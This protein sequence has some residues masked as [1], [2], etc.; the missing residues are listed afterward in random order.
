MTS[1][2]DEMDGSEML[3]L[4]TPA[5]LA[6]M[7]L[8]SAVNG[9]VQVQQMK[10]LQSGISQSSQV[11]EAAQMQTAVAKGIPHAPMQMKLTDANTELPTTLNKALN[12]LSLKSSVENILSIVSDSL[13]NLGLQV[14]SKRLERVW[15]KVARDSKNTFDIQKDQKAL[16]TELV[17]RYQ[18]SAKCSTVFEGKSNAQK[19]LIKSFLTDEKETF[20]HVRNARNPM[21]QK[22]E[23]EE[24]SYNKG[25]L[26]AQ[27]IQRHIATLILQHYGGTEVQSSIAK[28][29]KSLMLSSNENEVNKLLNGEIT[30]TQDLIN[31]SESFLKSKNISKKK[32]ELLNKDRKIRHAMKLRLRLEKFVDGKAKVKVPE[33][34]VKEL[35]G[36]HAEIRISKAKGWNKED[37]YLPTGT[38]YPCMGCTLYFQSKGIVISLEMGPMWLTDSALSTQ[39]E[40]ELLNQCGIGKLKN[41]GELAKTL[42]KQYESLNPNVKMGH[43]K[44]RGGSYDI[45]HDADSDSDVEGE[46]LEKIFQLITHDEKDEEIESK[47]KKSK[48]NLDENKE[49]EELINEENLRQDLDEEI[50][51]EKNDFVL[52]EEIDEESNEFN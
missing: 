30:T 47:K 10:T 26:K 29:G 35:D 14:D 25:K 8:Q 52:E 15:N 9:S 11:R 27:Q 41:A 2:Q 40:K 42:Y 46:D 18:R 45:D 32:K 24:F 31:L 22:E 13:K 12:N 20:K 39:L 36:R 37:F 21:M 44:H 17:S 3:S 23:L 50:D 16:V 19:T 43:G 34:E 51:E 4:Q 38:K 33:N 7:R 1:G 48:I 49:Y 28:D 6:Q 5:S